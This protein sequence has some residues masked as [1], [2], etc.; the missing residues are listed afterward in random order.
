M[1]V[2]ELG[3]RIYSYINQTMCLIQRHSSV[4]KIR[5]S[6]LET[7]NPVNTAISPVPAFAIGPVYQAWDIDGTIIPNAPINAS[8]AAA[9]RGSRRG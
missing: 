8:V 3:I 6:T 2:N 4:L 1:N 7:T 9:P 5:Y